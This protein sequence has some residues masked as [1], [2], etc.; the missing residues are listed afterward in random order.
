MSHRTR[1]P[2]SS[3]CTPSRASKDTG[4][5]LSYSNHE[6][7]R[8]MISRRELI[9][10]MAALQQSASAQPARPSARPNFIIIV[11]DDHGFEDLG[12]QGAKDVKTPNFDV[13]AAS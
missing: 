10:G 1:S 6:I 3:A 12:C 11:S 4:N 2:R 5:G 7:I 8:G 9:A 13:L